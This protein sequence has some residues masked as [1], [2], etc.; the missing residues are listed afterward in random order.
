MAK[1]TRTKIESVGWLFWSI[2]FA[3][4]VGPNI[5]GAWQIVTEEQ[6]WPVPFGMGILSAGFLAAILAWVVNSFLHLRNRRQHAEAR[7]KSKSRSR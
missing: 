1:Q 3:L 2:A 5:Y 7:R 6:K 4:L